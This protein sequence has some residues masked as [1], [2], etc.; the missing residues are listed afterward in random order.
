MNM[1]QDT[2]GHLVNSLCQG[3][4]P[5][6]HLQIILKHRKQFQELYKKC[7]CYLIFYAYKNSPCRKDT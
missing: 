2:Y 4:I 7:E 1:C 3:N 6:G 5:F